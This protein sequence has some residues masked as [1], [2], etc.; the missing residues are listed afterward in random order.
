MTS[1]TSPRTQIE[2]LLQ[3]I[4]VSAIEAMAEYEKTGHGIPFPG[5]KE[6][7]PLDSQPGALALKRAI[8]TLEGACERLCTT[9]A[10]PM[11]TL[12]NRAASYEAPCLEFVVEEGIADILEMGTTSANHGAEGMHIDEIAARTKRKVCSEKLG[13]VMLLLATRGCFKEVSKDVYTNN[14]ISLPLL[15]SNPV[16]S[17]ISLYSGDVARAVTVLPKTLVHPEYA[18]NKGIRKTAHSYL[19]RKKMENAS[20]FDWLEA[21]LFQRGMVGLSCIIGSSD[22]TTSDSGTN[23]VTF[24]DVGSGPG[25]VAL[26]LSKFYANKFRVVL[27]DLPA[28]L[29]NA[30]SLWLAEHPEA[31]VHFVPLDFLKETPVA[32]QDVYFLSFIILDWPDTDAISILKNVAS[33]MKDTSCLLLHEY[34]L[35]HCHPQNDED[36]H[37]PSETEEVKLL[38]PNYGSGD[39]RTHSFNVLM[40]ALYNTF[41]RTSEDFVALGRQAGLK[42]VKIWPLADTYLLEYRLAEGR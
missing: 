14:R 28:P 17:T 38:L 23:L 15:S 36:T 8:R 40:L 1:I 12:L 37:G 3:L 25:A 19:M 18:F 39:I 24:C 11:H 30:K 4:T 41:V 32:K 16:S 13:P 42:L 33:V 6:S 10:Q 22:A 35:Q 21:N 20:Y 29:E 27:Q 9:L 31:D 5:S 26:A 7:H 34:I 2:A